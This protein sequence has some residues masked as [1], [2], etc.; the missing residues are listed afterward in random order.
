HRAGPARRP[1]VLFLSV[2]PSAF[3]ARQ[4]VLTLAARPSRPRSSA[5]VASGRARTSARRRSAW[6]AHPGAGRRGARAA[7][8]PVSR[9]RCF[10]RRTQDSLTRY[11]AAAARVPRPASQ[12]A[13]TRSRKSIEYARMA[14]PPGPA[15][16]LRNSPADRYTPTQPALGGSQLLQPSTHLQPDKP[17]AQGEILIHRQCDDVIRHIDCQ[18]S[19]TALV[20]E[21]GCFPAGIPL[22]CAEEERAVLQVAREPL[23]AKTFRIQPR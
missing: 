3:S 22:Q 14:G 15:I 4:T 23:R 16:V 12:S 17:L 5:S 18:Y 1:A 21:S 10:S 2:R 8:A 6:A 19:S 13:S 9:R 11:F 20:R 7:T